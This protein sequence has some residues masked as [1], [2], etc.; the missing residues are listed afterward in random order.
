MAMV[1]ILFCSTLATVVYLNVLQS[2]NTAQKLKAYYLA[3]E[4][5]QETV[6]KKNYLDLNLQS[7][8]FMLDKSCK[9]Y[10]G[11]ELLELTIVIRNADGRLLW[12]QRQVV[13]NE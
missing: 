11:A 6:K 8:E 7:G 12:E 1:I 5:L 2:Q 3:E 4:I 10:K 13:G 9:P